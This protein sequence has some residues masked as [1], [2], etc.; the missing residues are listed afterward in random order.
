MPTIYA[1]YRTNATDPTNGM[2]PTKCVGASQELLKQQ[3]RA[4]PDSDWVIYKRD[5]GTTKDVICDLVVDADKV[6]K[7]VEPFERVRVNV[8]GQVRTKH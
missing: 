1:A 7:C 8:Q 4:V 5:L 2:T 6:M 3:L